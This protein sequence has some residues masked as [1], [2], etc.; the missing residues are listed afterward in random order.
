MDRDVDRGG[1][2]QREIGDDP[3]IAVLRNV[4]DA[5]AR[6]DAGGFEFRGERCSGVMCNF[7]PRAPLQLA[8]ADA[9]ERTASFHGYK[10]F[11]EE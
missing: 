2:M 4:G 1:Q 8:V 9:A 7:C 5:I 3:L 11:G 6:V 10:P